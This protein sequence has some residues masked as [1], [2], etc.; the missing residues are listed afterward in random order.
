[1]FYRVGKPRRLEQDVVETARPLHEVLNGTHSVVLDGT[2]QAPVTKLKPF[3][4]QRA[5]L[6]NRHALFHRTS[7]VTRR[8]CGSGKRVREKVGTVGFSVLHG[9][10]G[11]SE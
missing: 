3:L 1:M 11:M 6:P 2:T 8:G 5:F 4:V 9:G 10:K 7:C